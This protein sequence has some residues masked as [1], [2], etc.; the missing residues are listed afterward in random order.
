MTKIGIAGYG[1]VGQA[2]GKVYSTNNI[3]F[4]IQD[5]YKQIDDNFENIVILNICL[6]FIEKNSFVSIVEEY[7]N[8]STNLIIIHS[9]IGLGVV[10]KLKEKYPSLY[11]VHSPLR[12]VHPNL[13]EGLM[14]FKKFIGGDLESCKVANKHLSSLGMNTVITDS[15]TAVLSKLFSTTYYGLCIAFT[16][17]MG[18]ICD[19]VGANFEDIIDWNKDYNETYTKLGKQNVSRPI[20]YRIPDKKIGGHCVVPNARILKNLFPNRN[21]FDLILKY[22]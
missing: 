14:K 3:D 17:E 16:E 7:I 4:A 22:S 19:Q 8:N 12:G 1:E 10:E 6:P 13:Y 11:I 9:T 15:K 18:Q 5:K 20:L 2:L 21:V